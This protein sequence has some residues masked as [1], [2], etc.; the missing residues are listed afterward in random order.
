MKSIFRKQNEHHFVL[1]TTL[2]FSIHLTHFEVPVTIYA[3]EGK[4][5]YRKSF[6]SG[7]QQHKIALSEKCSL[8]PNREVC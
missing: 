5:Y 8:L 4:A 1:S 7:F 6:F 2:L 3:L